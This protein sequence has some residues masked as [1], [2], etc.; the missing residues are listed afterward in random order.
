[1][2]CAEKGFVMYRTIFLTFLFFIIIYS[3]TYSQPD[4]KFE[5][6]SFSDQL[7]NI[8]VNC[9]HQD[10][11]GFI[12]LGTVKGLYRY[13][14]YKLK[15]YTHNPDDP[16]SIS[17]TYVLTIYEDP[18]DSG[19]VLWIGTGGGLSK[20]NRVNGRF[21]NYEFRKDSSSLK[22]DG[23]GT[24]CKDK[25]GNHWLGGDGLK[26]F[27][28]ESGEVTNYLK[29]I[30]P[31][32]IYTIIEDHSGIIWGGS[33]IGLIK[34]NQ[35]IKDG[36]NYTIYDV[37][38]DN[39]YGMGRN[40]V[41]AVYEDRKNVLW[42]GTYDGIYIF[43]A[44]SGKF[45]RPKLKVGD[46]EIS[47]TQKI[48]EDKKGNL[49]A[50]GSDLIKINSLRDTLIYYPQYADFRDSTE[51]L[52][53]NN[54]C[55]DNSGNIWVSLGES[56]VNKIIPVR[57]K[58][59]YFSHNPNDKFSLPKNEVTSFVEDNL[60]VVWLTTAWDGLVKFEKNSG[61]FFI[62][63]GSPVALN[64]SKGPDGVL[65]FSCISA[66]C[67]FNPET[68]FGAPHFGNGILFPPGFTEVTDNPD[69]NRVIRDSLYNIVDPDMIDMRGG[70][71]AIL[72][73]FA[74]SK[75]V[76]WT[77]H[78]PTSSLCQY[79]QINGRYV[80]YKVEVDGKVYN[81]FSTI[82]EDT[83]G[84]LWFGTTGDGLLKRI[85]NKSETGQDE[86]VEYTEELNNVNSL[87]NNYVSVI[88]E[89]S[90]G[91]LWVGTANGL[92]KF[93]PATETFTRY[94]VKDGLPSG[95]IAGIVVD[96]EGNIWVSSD[97]GLSKLDPK[98]GVIKNYDKSNGLQAN[99]FSEKS[100]YKDS[101][102]NIYFGGNN[103]FN[104]FKPSDILN[105]SNIPQ[106]RIVGFQLFNKNI[107]PGED[108]PLK[109]SLE[110]SKKIILD[111]DQD[112]FTLE[113]AALEYSNPERNQFAYKMEGIDPDWVYT[114]AN[115][116][117]ATYTKLDP[118][119]YTFR[120]KA[121]NNDGIWNEEGASI[122]VI[123]LPPWWR[124]NWAYALYV[125]LIISI[126]TTAW[127]IQSN[128]LRLKHQAEIE[129]LQVEKYQE[130]D[131]LKSHFFANISHEFRTPLTLIL[132]PVNS[133]LE[134]FKADSA[135]SELKVV[136]RNAERLLQLVNQLLD[137]SKL[138]AGKMQL[139]TSEENIVSLVKGM[140]LSFVSLAE[141]KKINLNFNSFVKKLDVYIDREKF[142][143]VI[144]NLLSNA[145]KFTSEGGTIEI[146]VSRKENNV[147]INISDTGIGIPNQ[148]LE[149]I[150]DRFY[151]VD[152]SHTREQEG[153]GIG[154]SL[155]KELVD[156]QRGEIFVN[157]EE[158]KGTT[159]TVTLPLGKEHLKPEEIIGTSERD[160]DDIFSTNK[161]EIISDN[162]NLKEKIDI[163]I[164]KETE[165]PILLIV[166]DNADVRNYIKG[167]FESEYK[168]IEAVNGKEGLEKSLKFI[169]DLI[170]SDVM[171]PKMDGIELC[172]K[173]KT[174]ER[175]S[176]IPV[177]LLTAKASEQDKISGL[178]TGADDYLMKPFDV[179][180]LKVRIRNLIEQRKKLREHFRKVGLFDFQTEKINNTDKKFLQNAV[181]IINKNISD[182]DF[183][184]QMFADSMAMSRSQLHRKLIALIDE[185][186]GD[187]IRRIRLTKAA[188]LIEQ[189]FGNISEIALEV[190]YNN[191][192]NFTRSF[193]SH[194]G[195]SPSQYQNNKKS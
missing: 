77:L 190:G 140:V 180:E 144:N 157:S 5:R 21:Y 88:A 9:I 87:S 162:E 136:R 145:I 33:N 127:R 171:M 68:G 56:G 35:K 3:S 92:N 131:R 188:K 104:M 107:K 66:L 167:Y 79:D 6:P 30:E 14:G 187:L 169:P 114:D 18:V 64:V 38:K 118:G 50:C 173:L 166:E 65:W 71:N 41:S 141:T 176:H 72:Y 154:L 98:T 27:N 61:R 58:F 194:F 142:A 120:V 195:V 122:N 158:G 82:F 12:W 147:E 170:V 16:Y 75:G 172:S 44:E 137:L 181:D 34:L 111:S 19:K 31:L 83:R 183:N 161:G 73:C 51:S 119:E 100:C 135:V 53:V 165:K 67:S 91:F 106:V 25:Y 37:I 96:D 126:I 108:S 115:R 124:T 148:K 17:S 1:M 63:G 99:V 130:I 48:V 156:L 193:T 23:V 146:D 163:E 57:T 155:T 32:I 116:S 43:D 138:E 97:K 184:V 28:K 11:F 46:P 132:G 121:S 36:E 139:R 168:L 186:P 174:D 84:T 159:F 62:A 191:P 13:D 24:I 164:I 42:I 178:E 112:V 59:K 175:T 117:F 8:S 110:F 29:N 69:R 55:T 45:I 78:G 105:N 150:F 123:I 74:D 113:F 109:K 86:F 76:I 182:E 7:E 179:R 49:W 26:R 152:G 4:Y 80:P 189:N 192:A 47:L 101:K 151:Q 103:G 102:G 2:F 128:R 149:K 94:K 153:T 22:F 52:G 10:Y 85:E 15:E 133:L 177:I 134:K 93:D 95:V 40:M 185:S 129:H 70:A 89:D 54:F 60:G 90:S 81:S 160:K 125:L 20:L 143:K 39:P